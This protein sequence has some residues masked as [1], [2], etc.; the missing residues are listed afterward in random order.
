MKKI[1]LFLFYNFVKSIVE[2]AY[3]IYFDKITYINGERMRAGHPCIIASNHP[4]C[5]I[6]VMLVAKKS[7]RIV[8]FLANAGL[9]KPP[10]WEWFFTTFYT[11]PIQRY[12]DTGG[13]PLKNQEAFN[14][15]DEFL[16][17]GGALFIA[18]QGTSWVERKLGELKTGTARIA[19]SAA[20]L[21]NFETELEIIPVGVTYKDPL[22]F[23]KSALVQIGKPIKISTYKAEY[24]KHPRT[25]AKKLTT[26][27]TEAMR[28][29]VIDAKT[30]ERDELLRKHETLLNGKNPLPL[31][32]EFHRTEKVLTSLNKLEAENEV[33]FENLEEKTN[34]YFDVLDSKGINDSAVAKQSSFSVFKILLFAIGFPLFL[35]GLVNNLLSW[36]IPVL[37][38]NNIKIYKGFYSSI[39]LM[40]G[41]LTTPIFYSIQIFLVSWIF[42]N[43]IITWT[44]AI[45]LIPLGYFALWYYDH[46]QNFKKS[47]KLSRN[48]KL[49]EN[50]TSQRKELV[51]EVESLK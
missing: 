7:N 40:A 5:L 47:W 3:F 8:H 50:L 20:A 16:V 49:I 15:C 36:G 31:A 24:E 51:S 25:A 39:K 19:L 14:K 32:T 45:L 1:L 48:S 26:E 41:T 9:F 29:L 6:D 42:Q 12:M 11:I 2:I 37:I 35:F 10:F 27:L 44:Y 30:D 21:Q 4:N 46:F 43:S 28:I 13:K 18:P 33:A 23:R 38:K 34:Q 17:G 22:A